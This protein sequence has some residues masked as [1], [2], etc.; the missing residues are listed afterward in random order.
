MK[1]YGVLAVLVAIAIGLA[2]PAIAAPL[3]LADL[4]ANTD[5]VV[6]LDDLGSGMWELSFIAN[7]ELWAVTLGIADKANVF[8]VNFLGQANRWRVV[9]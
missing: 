3:T 6:Q 1:Q 9:G 7:T 8:N 5:A 4:N 2:T